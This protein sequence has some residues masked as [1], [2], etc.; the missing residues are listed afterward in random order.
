M[1]FM[2]AICLKAYALRGCL[3]WLWFLSTDM[4]VHRPW[5]VLVSESRNGI[6]PPMKV[7]TKLR[8]TKPF[9]SLLMF[10]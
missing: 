1:E 9:G 4:T 5:V 6:R 7:D 2:F 10:G 8:I 3:F